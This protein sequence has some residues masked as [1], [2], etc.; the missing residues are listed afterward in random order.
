MH[1][2]MITNVSRWLQDN[3]KDEAYLRR[4]V[5]P[6]EALLTRY[7]RCVVKDSAINALCYGAKLMIPGAR[8]L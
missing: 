3:F 1:Q 8:S 5:M 4:V 6:L 2:P 7:K